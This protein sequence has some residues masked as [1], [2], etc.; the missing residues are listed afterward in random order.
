MSNSREKVLHSLESIGIAYELHEHHP[1]FSGEEA[2]EIWENLDASICKNLFLR[3]YKGRNHYLIVLPVN[4]VFELKEFASHYQIQRP[5]FS[6][7]QRLLK[8]LGVKPGAVSPFGL[9]NDE[10][11]HV[12][13]F[14]S[15]Q[16]LDKDRIAFHPNDNTATVVIL[17]D[18]LV[19]YLN[20]VGNKYEFLPI[21]R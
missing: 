11:N 21:F 9:I 20:W 17:K 7:E 18:D 2:G 10:A 13:V 8:Y 4:E 16:V 3:D 6:S 12:L 1:V 15:K 19:K 14:L 5:G